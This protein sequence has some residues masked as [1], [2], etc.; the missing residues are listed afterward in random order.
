[1]NNLQDY[2]KVIPNAIPNELCDAIVSEYKDCADWKE[3]EIEFGLNKDVRNCR[4]I[5][6]STQELI[7]RKQLDGEIFKCVTNLVSF[8]QNQFPHWHSRSDTG[9]ELLEYKT[10]GF[11]KTHVDSFKGAT[12]SLSCSFILNDNFEGGEF[13]FFDRM[14]NYKVEK[15]SAIIF[16]ANFMY[17][18]EIL[19][20]ISGTRY[21]IITWLQ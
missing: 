13:S 10:G 5:L 19:P 4:T 14:L 11:Y 7:S 6:L 8:Y 18:H 16:P 15:G 9:Y 2:I 20:V 21:S 12:R 17:P 3:A 1:M